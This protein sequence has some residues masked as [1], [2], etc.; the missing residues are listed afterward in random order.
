MRVCVRVRMRVRACLCVVNGSLSG[1]WP[2][3]LL[4]QPAPGGHGKRGLVADMVCLTK[5]WSCQLLYR[6]CHRAIG[7]QRCVEGYAVVRT[8]ARLG[9][10][11][12]KYRPYYALSLPDELRI[13]ALVAG[14]IACQL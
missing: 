5:P 7:L 2:K 14:V 11:D 3:V 1:P 8:L 4:Q 6:V 13:S 9:R 12:A 10:A